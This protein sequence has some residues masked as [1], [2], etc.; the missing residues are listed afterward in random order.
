MEPFNVSLVRNFSNEQLSVC[1][2]ILCEWLRELGY[3]DIVGILPK[4]GYLLQ[5]WAY[6]L[7]DYAGRIFDRI[8]PNELM[9][10]ICQELSWEL[11]Q[12]PDTPRRNFYQETP[13]NLKKIFR[14]M[15]TIYNY[16]IL[17]KP[18]AKL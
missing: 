17:K 6:T 10:R 7:L 9:A 14:Q 5:R 18:K 8:N 15:V 11:P 4:T 13:E 12:K 16:E 1:S 3:S 2:T